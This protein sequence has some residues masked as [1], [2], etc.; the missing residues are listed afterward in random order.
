MTCSLVGSWRT[1]FEDPETWNNRNLAKSGRRFPS[2]FY[3]T[4]L[5]E[6][7]CEMPENAHIY[8]DRY[9]FQ[10]QN[11]STHHSN[12]TWSTHYFT[13]N[14]TTLLLSYYYFAIQDQDL[15]HPRHHNRGSSANNLLTVRK[16]NTLLVMQ[17]VTYS[18]DIEQR[19]NPHIH[20]GGIPFYEWMALWSRS[21][22][23]WSNCTSE[24]R[25]PFYRIMVSL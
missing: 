10:I 11:S 6:G 17:I 19:S 15:K 1:L 16:W 5:G 12:N 23:F 22:D 9:K 24:N 20:N 21:K 3:W 8:I 18:T 2:I 4:M 25:Y 13:N 7:S 14:I